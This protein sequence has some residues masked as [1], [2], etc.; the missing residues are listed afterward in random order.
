MLLLSL[1]FSQT[2][3]HIVDIGYG[4][5]A[6]CWV[7]EVSLC[8]SSWSVGWANRHVMFQRECLVSELSL[9]VELE[10]WRRCHCVLQLECWVGESSLYVSAG[11][12]DQRSI[13]VCLAGV[14]AEVSLCISSWSVGWANR[15]FM[16]QRECL[17]SELSLCVELQWWRRCHCVLQLER[18][19]SEVLLCGGWS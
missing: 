13:A 11:V 15:H 3:C 9:R 5:H 6:G 8:I 18:L 14:V 19:V 7:S 17:I 16:F 1:S 2:A 10:W 4:S 12:F